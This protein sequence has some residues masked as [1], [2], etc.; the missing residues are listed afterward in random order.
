MA[1]EIK[2]D[3]SLCWTYTGA[4]NKTH[5]RILW[6]VWLCMILLLFTCIG[7]I[8]A[9][10]GL[11]D[12]M[13]QF[14]LWISLG[15]AGF[16]TVV[17]A[18]IWLW[19]RFVTK[20]YSYTVDDKKLTVAYGRYRRLF[21]DQVKSLTQQRERNVILLKSSLI[22]LEIYVPDEDYNEVWDYLTAHCLNGQNQ[23]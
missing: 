3:G 6:I 4:G 12:E 11:S 14:L 9:V 2:N 21:L 22:P 16:V 15:L 17:F 5:C 8:S 10:S 23:K 18:L 20:N 19:E 1:V 7:I 13:N